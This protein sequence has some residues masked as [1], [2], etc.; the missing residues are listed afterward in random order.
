MKR[1]VWASALA[2]LL[3][4]PAAHANGRFPSASHVVI[5]PS[6][7]TPIVLRTT[8][9]LLVSRDHGTVWDWS[10]ESAAGYADEDPVVGVTANET[11]VLGLSSSLVA[12]GDLCTWRTHGSTR[13]IDVVVRRDDARVALA[14]TESYAGPRDGGL[15]FDN[16]VL[17]STDDGVTWGP[18]AA[19][20][21]ATIRMETIEVSAGGDLFVSG[22]RSEGVQRSGVFFVSQDGGA[23]WVERP[24]PLVAGESAPFIAGVDPT[25]AGR[26]YVRTSGTNGDRL[27]VTT[28]MGATWATAYT[29]QGPMLG[30]TVSDDGAAVYLGGPR[31]GLWVAPRTT[32]QFTKL[33]SRVVSCLASSGGHLWSCTPETLGTS[34]DG[35]LSFI[36]VLEF[37]N[38]RGPVACAAGTAGA[39]CNG[40]WPALRVRLG[41]PDRSDGGSVVPPVADAAVAPPDASVSAL[42][43]AG[44]PADDGW[45]EWIPRP[46]GGCSCDAASGA[47]GSFGFGVLG[48]A[49]F[50]WTRR[51]RRRVT[52]PRSV[53]RR[54]SSWRP[55]CTGRRRRTRGGSTGDR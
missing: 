9:G 27:L 13:M 17:R 48:V 42:P 39:A 12:S 2:A 34:H 16:T 1:L 22:T 38:I 46:R 51:A 35:G 20:V 36:E 5:G 21:D 40:E 11:V 8:F 28:D 45:Y 32:M 52:T 37:K 44:Q 15:L 50:A 24:L 18:L 7:S 41:I 29:T 49:L 10:C 33:S 30:F 19:K 54:E 47:G 6:G 53:F 23:S 26:V 55:P 4:A 25:A 14:I 31:D 3:T 43:P